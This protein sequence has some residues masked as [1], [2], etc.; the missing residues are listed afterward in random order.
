M[1]TNRNSGIKYN[2]IGKAEPSQGKDRGD[3][4]KVQ[5]RADRREGSVRE[6]IAWYKLPGFSPLRRNKYI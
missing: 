3:D 1:E 4:N 2:I 5:S 6:H